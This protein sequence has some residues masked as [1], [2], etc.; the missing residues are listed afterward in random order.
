[1]AKSKEKAAPEA[2]EQILR[3]YE[4][5]YQIS[6]VT[7][8]EDVEKVVSGIRSVLEKAGGSFIS[9]GAPALT[10]LAYGIPG[11]EGGKSVLFDRAFFGWLK[12]E[13][14]VQA[15]RELENY[16]KTDASILRAIVFRTVRQ[17]TRAKFKA[18]TLRDVKRGDA[19]KTIRK[20]E[21]AAPVSEAD[22]DKALETITAE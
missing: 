21:N 5:G 9:E 8:E 3:I 22:L 6:P 17:D 10:R 4:A 19:I 2:A 7:K 15:A 12:F 20:E 14:S 18:P 11:M 13:S 1:M 16:L